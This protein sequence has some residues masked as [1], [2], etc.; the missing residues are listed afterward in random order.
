[1][2][3]QE[4]PPESAGGHLL[5]GGTANPYGHDLDLAVQVPQNGSGKTL[6]LTCASCHDHHGNTN[7]RNLR[8]D[9]ADAGDSLVVEAGRDV[10]W[11]AAPAQPPTANG[12]AAAYALGNIG[13]RSGLN[14]WCTSCH[15]QIAAN[16][17]AA[18]PAHFNAHPTEVAVGGFSE[19]KH[20]DVRHWLTGTGEGFLVENPI[21]GE[22]IPRLPFLQPEATD[23]ATSRQVQSTNELFCGTCHG[24]HGTS[25]ARGLRWPYVEGGINY[26]SGCQQCHYK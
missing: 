2:Y 11:N 21:A 10:F 18:P 24:A 14:A 6:A 9:P 15:D 25:H 16:A 23:V 17:P 8:F 1:M 20:V 7:Y 12:S 19:S 22:G 4:Q 5:M 3:A 13:Y 26:L